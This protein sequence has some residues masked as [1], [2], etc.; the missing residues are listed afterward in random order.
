M[1][2]LFP[3]RKD[4]NPFDNSTAPFPAPTSPVTPASPPPPLSG[5]PSSNQPPV[6]P[7]DGPSATEESNSSGKGK[8]LRTKR[9]IWISITVIL[10]FIILVL[11]L[12]LLVKWCYR[13]KEDSDWMSKRNQAGPYKGT[14]PSPRDNG[15]LEQQSHPIEKGMQIF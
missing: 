11:A 15:S 8:G 9:I 7:A 12:V 13:E 5:S 14:R 1:K 4:G 10:V 2:C 6:K 3:C